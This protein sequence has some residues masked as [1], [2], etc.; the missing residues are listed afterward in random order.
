MKNG[1]FTLNGVTSHVTENEN[2]GQDSLHG[3]IVGYDQRNWTMV[4]QNQSSI[5]FM[6]E[7]DAFEGYPGKVVNYATFSVAMGEEGPSLATRLVSIPLD[8]PTPIMLTTHPY[9]N[10]NA[11]VSG[12][13]PN[14]LDHTLSMPYSMRYVKIDN[15]EVATGDIGVV[16]SQDKGLL[17]F[18]SPRSLGESLSANVQE[19]GFN[20]TG[21]DTNFIIDRPPSAGT[22]STAITVLS[23][24]SNITGIK[25]DLYTNQQALIVYTCNKLNGSIP[26]KQSQQHSQNQTTVYATEHSC[27]A[28]ETQGWIDG[29]NHPEWGQQEYQ[30]FSYDT[31]PAV[32]W[33]KYVFGLV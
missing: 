4:S 12:T 29:I 3:G 26:L 9:W 16:S 18:T 19:C 32:M 1:T 5:T 30:V 6:L 11:F 2:D 33:V 13:N 23:L 17:D 8:G 31:Q 20:C 7:D 27:V 24:S 14:I 28:I 10:L 25:F 22:E 15:I 21:I